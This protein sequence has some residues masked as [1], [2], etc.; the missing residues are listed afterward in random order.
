MVTMELCNLEEAC[1]RNTT[2][3]EL[4]LSKEDIILPAL[5]RDRIHGPPLAWWFK[6]CCFLYSVVGV[7]MAFRLAD[8]V[9]ICPA[10][11]WH[12]EAFLL[13]LQGCLSFLHDAHFQGRS[14]MAK[15]LDR[16]CASFLT[17][18]QPIKFA[19][20]H[21]DSGQLLLLALSWTIGLLCFCA[22]ARA[23]AAG[24]GLRY[25]VFHTCWHIALP[26]GGFL[27]IEYT[28]ALTNGGLADVDGS[29]LT[30]HDSNNLR[31]GTAPGAGWPAHDE[32]RWVSAECHDRLAL[33]LN[34]G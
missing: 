27:W 21:M 2:G 9:C 18:C 15:T 17:M 12:L 1:G 14:T 25:Q 8:L 7:E 31:G 29:R 3:E 5:Y 24:K 19:F 34:R 23:F 28:R 16:T 10:Y 32:L 33:G 13:I 22:S 20:C 11:P 30:G 4:P 6:M 26:L